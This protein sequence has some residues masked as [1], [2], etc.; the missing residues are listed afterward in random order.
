MAKYVIGVDLGGTNIKAA[1]V[2]KGRILSKVSV[3][4]RADRGEKTVIANIIKA[5]DSVKTKDVKAVGIGSPGPLNYKTGMIISAPNLPFRNTKL[6]S[7][8]ERKTKLKV[9]IDNDANC[10]VLGE[11]IYG[12]G[13]GSDNVIGLTLGTGIGGGIIL[14]KK[15]F[16]GKLN[17]GEL[18][19]TTI[20]YD[21]YKSKCGNMGCLETYVSARGILRRAGLKGI[22]V[23]STK[24]LFELARKDAKAKQIFKETGFYL[25]VGITNFSLIF[26]PDVVVLGGQIADSWRFFAPTM[27]R[28][29]KQRLLIKPPKILK[30]KLNE[31]AILGAASLVD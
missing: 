28:T 29:V 24:E 9:E 25:G 22:R 20:N 2:S 14:N 7:I 19:H 5:I 16:H 21:G 12:A 6:K 4:T 27:K 1:L 23:N 17:A 10:F 26:D 31:A 30:A 13:K 18:G 15:I 3:K 8:L 11:T